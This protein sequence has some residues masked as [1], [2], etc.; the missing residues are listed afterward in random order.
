MSGSQYKRGETT[1]ERARHVCG[2]GEITRLA[3]EYG[4]EA[5]HKLFER[6]EAPSTW[7]ERSPKTD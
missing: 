5:T 7:R 2:L 6:L 1:F 3:S 4:R